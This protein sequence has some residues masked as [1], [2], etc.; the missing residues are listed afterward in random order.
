MSIKC[1]D[2]GL[3]VGSVLP[4]G[5]IYLFGLA[6]DANFICAVAATFYAPFFCR[7]R[8]PPKFTCNLLK[9]SVYVINKI[10]DSTN[11]NDMHFISK[12]KVSC[13]WSIRD[14]LMLVHLIQFC[15]R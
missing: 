1:P 4:K 10:R 14:I 7:I 9:S 2:S 5:T 13:W 6:S 15:R 3:Q 11:S 8:P 12:K